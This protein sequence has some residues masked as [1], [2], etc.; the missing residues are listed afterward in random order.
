MA[1]SNYPGIVIASASDDCVA[2]RDGSHLAIALET[3]QWPSCGIAEERS[4][5]IAIGSAPAPDPRKQ[6]QYA[7]AVSALL[8]AIFGLGPRRLPGSVAADRA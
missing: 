8:V 6:V 3:D 4:A 1:T 7:Q 2:P 5:T